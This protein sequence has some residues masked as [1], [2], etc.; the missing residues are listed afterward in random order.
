MARFTQRHWDASTFELAWTMRY[1]AGSCTT[2]IFGQ[3][4]SS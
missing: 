3:L 4:T 2:D 1:G